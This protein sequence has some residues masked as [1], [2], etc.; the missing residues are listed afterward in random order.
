MPLLAQ[1]RVAVD[2]NARCGRAAPNWGVG[3]GYWAL[4]ELE[5]QLLLG[6]WTGRSARHVEL[7]LWLWW[8]LDFGSSLCEFF[9]EDFLHPLVDAIYEDAMSYLEFDGEVV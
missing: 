8:L 3:V 5:L 2:E 9:P 4:P 6:S 1:Q 7:E